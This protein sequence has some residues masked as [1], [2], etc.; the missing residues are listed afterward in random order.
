MS[1][2]DSHPEIGGP[3]AIAPRPVDKTRDWYARVAVILLD[4]VLLFLF[5]NLVIYLIILAGR[6]SQQTPLSR[7]GGDKILKSY[8]GW[9]AEDVE[10]LLTET[11]RKLSLGYEP[12]TG[13]REKPFRG[14]FVNVDRAGFRFSKDQAP[15]PPGRE[16]INV[17]VFGGSTTFGM[18][19]PDDQTIPSYMGK[20]GAEKGSRGLAVYNFG[21]ESYFSTQEMILFL[22]LLNGGLVPEVAVFIDGINE[23]DPDHADGQP[24]FAGAIRDF[25]DGKTG[26][27]LPDKIPAVRAVHWLRS[28][29]TK[30]QP[31]KVTNSADRAALEGIISRWLANK[32]IIESIAKRYGVRTIFVWQPIPDYKYDLHNQ[33]F[34]E[35]TSMSDHPGYAL[36]DN[37]R[38]QGKL[39]A[40][41]LWLADMQQDKQENLYVDRWHYNAKFSREIAGRICD[42]LRENLG[43]L[44]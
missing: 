8:P 14:R 7:Y 23:F 27:K 12:F 6:P 40:N 21:R 19:L 43:G 9:R 17:F 36:M 28:H 39:G 35:S 41:I 13:F 24:R 10:T 4:C 18:G 11:W 22:Q 32:T 42:C 1:P 33:P 26:S 15:W 25:M 34:Y 2:V 31:Q 16:A 3:T 5:L 37:L 20:C 29:W 30:P 44:R 38:A